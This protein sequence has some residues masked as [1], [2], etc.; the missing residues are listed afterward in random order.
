M[1]TWRVLTRLWCH[2]VA[3]VYADRLVSSRDKVW[4]SNVLDLC[5]RYC[6]CGATVQSDNTDSQVSESGNLTAKDMRG[7]VHP[8][9]RPKQ[10]MRHIVTTGRT[11]SSSNSAGMTIFFEE[12]E[13]C[14]VNSEL[15]LHLLPKNSQVQFIP[16]DEVVM[17][18]EDLSRLMFAKLPVTQ[19]RE[20]ESKPQQ[21]TESI[22]PPQ[23]RK[24]D[25]MN[26]S[27]TGS[28]EEQS[29]SDTGTSQESSELAKQFG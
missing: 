16:Y 12:I 5:V 11:S 7:R 20:L 21:D 28:E 17:R 29:T 26:A 4:F 18:G 25:N 1:A 6:F 27:D 13:A 3:R 14:N 23:E 2:E 24:D 8:D 15:L 22:I 9:A 19:E 10:R